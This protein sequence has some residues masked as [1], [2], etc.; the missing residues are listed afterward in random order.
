VAYAR[1]AESPC[2]PNDDAIHIR[3]VVESFDYP[4][5]NEKAIDYALGPFSDTFSVV[6]HKF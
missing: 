6:Q 1:I 4:Y 3:P 2:F 5:P